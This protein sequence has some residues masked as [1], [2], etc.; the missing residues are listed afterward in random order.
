MD[1]HKKGVVDFGWMG[2]IGKSRKKV[3]LCIDLFLQ[4]IVINP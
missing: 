3:D 2:G 4:L 1:P